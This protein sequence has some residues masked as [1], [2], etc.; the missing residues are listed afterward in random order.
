MGSVEGIPQSPTERVPE[1]FF[2]DEERILND[3]ASGSNFTFKRGEKWAINPETGEATFDPKFFEEKGYT[4]S[5]ALFAAFH[6]IRCHLVELSETLDRDGGEQAYQALKDRSENKQWVHIWENCRTDLKGNQT[7]LQFA[8]SLRDQ[9]RTLYQEK[10]FSKVDLTESPKHMQFMYAVLRKGMVPDE[11]LIIDPAVQEAIDKLRNVK[12]KDVISLATDPNQDPL[13]ALKLSQRYIEP[14]IEQLVKEDLEDKKK[15]QGEGKGQGESSSDPNKAFADDYEDYEDKHPEPMED[16]E[17]EKKIKEIKEKQGTDSR[18]EAGYEN[19]E[20]ISKK[21]AADY[22][23]EFRQVD[24]FIEPLREVLRRIVESRKTEVRRLK[25]MKKEGVMVDPALIPQT[26]IEVQ[27]G[28]EEP[29]TMKDFEGTLIEENVPGKFNLRLVA[30]QSGSMSGDK[31][32]AQRRSA[33]L[34][35]EALKEFS[36]MLDEDRGSLAVDLEVQTELRAFGISSL[37]T[38]LYKPLSKE[39]TEKQRIEFFKGLLETSGGTNDYDSLAEIEKDVRRKIAE[40]PQ[41]SEE[42][43]SGKRREIVIVLSDG[44]SGN[45]TSAKD[46]IQKLRDL[47]VKVVGLG[48]TSQAEGIKNTYSPEGRI[49]YNVGD[50]PKALQDMLAEYLTT[51]SLSEIPEDVMSMIRES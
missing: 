16:D 33:I 1:N 49:C 12:G 17:T 23:N 46:K 48:M 32:V 15:Q 22:F 41:Y 5:Q 50:L 45:V 39:L 20:G 51:L 24:R 3:I 13:L 43:K 30:D 21:E 10:L 31:A 6:E 2:S 7:I 27:A 9:A 4:P 42:L 47:G 37:G 35:M 26:Y 18:Q 14:I 40:D 44:D 34:V 11:D 25:S 8:P 38:K 19:A 36:D 29:P 28:N